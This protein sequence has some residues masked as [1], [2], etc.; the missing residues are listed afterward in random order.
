MSVSIGPGPAIGQVAI[1]GEDLRVHLD[2]H[3]A[4][5]RLADGRDPRTV[6]GDCRLLGSR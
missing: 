6:V 4:T 5:W 3:A 1:A 2:L